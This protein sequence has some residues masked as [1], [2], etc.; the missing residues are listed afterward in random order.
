MS[1]TGESD[2]VDLWR[3]DDISLG[4]SV[5]VLMFET[6][7][8]DE[9]DFVI[10]WD[11]QQFSI[12]RTHVACGHRRGVFVWKRVQELMCETCE[13]DEVDLR[14]SDIVFARVF[15]C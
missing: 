8:S 2:E 6:G 15:K 10:C 3:G 7:E 5:Q 11:Q 9:V 13:S 1:Q 12:C 4:T 14:R